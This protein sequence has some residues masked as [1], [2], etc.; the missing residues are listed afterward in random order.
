M[1]TVHTFIGALW[2]VRLQSRGLAFSLVGLTWV[3][4]ALWVGIGNGIHKNYETPVPVRSSNSTFPLPLSYCTSI[5]VG[6]IQSTK[7]N[8]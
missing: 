4:G 8:A 3:F 1:L 6:L 5:G 2:R 7:G